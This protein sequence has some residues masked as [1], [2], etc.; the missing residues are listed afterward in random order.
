MKT[1]FR[2]VGFL[3]P[4]RGLLALSLLL[5]ALFSIL[6]TLSITFVQP[7]FQ[8]LFQEP[9]L[10]RPAHEISVLERI[11]QDFYASI[12]HIL[13]EGQSKEGALLRLGLLIVAV[14][15]AKN[16]VK[17]LGIT[18][19]TL[20][21]ERLIKSIRDAVFNKILGLSMD[22]FV[23]HKTGALVSLITNDVATMHTTITPT[24]ST[25]V[26]EPLQIMLFLGLLLAISPYLTFMAFSTSIVALLLIRVA[27]RYLRKY[28]TRM[29][30]SMAN[31]TAIL[32]EALS[33][34]RIIK[35]FSME[36]RVYSLFFHQTHRYTR[37]ASKYQ[38]VYDV[39]PGVSEMFA[40]IALTVVLFIGGN[41]V[42]AGKMNS[43]ELMTFL[44]ALFSIMS[45]L[46]NLVSI[47]AQ[48]Q[49][50]LVA[51]ETIFSVLDSTP[52]VTPGLQPA[53]K[54]TSALELH[55]VHFSYPAGSRLILND[56]SLRIARG[57]K[58]ALVGASGSG[59]STICDLIIRLYDPTQG[60]ITLDD[61]DIRT[62]TFESYHHLFGVVSQESVLFNDT[63]NNNI[64][65]GY[66]TATDEEIRLAA[67]IAH[68][69]EFIRQLPSGYSTLIGDRGVLLSGGQKQR[70]AIARALVGNPQII[71]FDEATSALDSESEKLVQEAMYEVLEQ[72][73]AIIIAH[74]LS[75]IVNADEIIVLDQGVIVER[76]K[77]EELLAANGMYKKL[78]DIQFFDQS[79]S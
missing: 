79:F 44:F 60:I 22:F 48:I 7:V 18:V 62:F 20:L 36:S 73:T 58:I 31:Y 32:Q 70:L 3:R 41:E 24:T 64:R 59:K 33:G 49:R 14:F 68:A 21:N 72:R 39:V 76:G 63:V 66:P 19:N 35:A 11:K 61:T 69:D 75:T 53:E 46:T 13:V 54:L 38:R 43:H 78:Y 6:T 45:P 34:I 28:A 51:A 17:Y 1:F 74:R 10:Q 8:I 30:E 16:I 5:G 15:L 42:F 52:T 4:F 37:T 50:G 26:R 77:H 9:A 57:K 47:P 2:I 56:I 55:H 71:I 12:S 67:R 29:Q 27:T 40:I 23:R 65:F 25:I